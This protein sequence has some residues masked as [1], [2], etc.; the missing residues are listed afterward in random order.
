MFRIKKE[1]KKINMLDKEIIT[2]IN[3]QIWLENNASFYYLDLSIKFDTEGFNGISKFFLDQ[4]NEER[5]HML[6]LVDYLLEKD[7]TPQLP[8]YNFME[9]SEEQFNVLSHFENSLYNER[10]ITESIN[11]I[12]SKCKELEDY[13]TENF[14][15]WFVSEQREEEAKFKSIIDDLKII[16]ED[17]VGLYNINK[18]LGNTPEETTE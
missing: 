7:A 3:E 12:V 1:K 9:D 14:I 2:L 13:T 6:M 18:L 10:R 8:Q 11:K 17:R 4:S 16:G 15:Q 5:T